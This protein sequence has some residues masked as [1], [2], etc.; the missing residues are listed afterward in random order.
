MHGQRQLKRCDTSEHLVCLIL[1]T[2]SDIVYRNMR[3]FWIDSSNIL[4][5]D[6]DVLWTLQ[7][8]RKLDV[9]RIRLLLCHC[10]SG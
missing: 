7:L 4:S 10:G 1:E 2:T 9:G 6:F 8:A 5:R 3:E